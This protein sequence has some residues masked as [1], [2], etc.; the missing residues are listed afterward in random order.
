MKWIVFGI[1]LMASLIHS[2]AATVTA[3]Y[4]ADTYLAGQL[5]NE[6]R[7][8]SSGGVSNV[9]TFHVGV[10]DLDVSSIYN[11]RFNFGAVRFDDLSSFEIGQNKFL[12]L[13]V[14]DFKTPLSVDPGYQGPPPYAYLATG[15]FRLAIVALTADFSESGT[16]ANL[17]SWYNTHL[18]SRPRIA[19]MVIT[20][21]GTFQVDVTATVDNW[22]SAP[23]T[24]FG[25]GLVG[26]DSIPT[27][28]T[29]RF[30]SME[31]AGNLGPVLIPEPAS[32]SLFL[33]G[34]A[35]VLAN[36]RRRRD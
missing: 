33:L 34:L 26:L 2:Q 4:D 5:Y 6:V 24:N 32:G 9:G 17:M 12:S 30:N 15:N 16:S 10:H 1:T 13:A 3:S 29:L 27:A 19:E 31:A 20:Q 14:K 8:G 11:M 18:Y 21:S 22:I 36:S 28:S 7:A 25:F 23:A 35:S